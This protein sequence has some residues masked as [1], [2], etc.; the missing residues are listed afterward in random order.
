M[1]F[2]DGLNVDEDYPRFEP[3]KAEDQCKC[4]FCKQPPRIKNF[5][6]EPSYV[7][8]NNEDCPI[9]EVRMDADDWNMS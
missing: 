8:C 5:N 1:K 9:F 4:R 6:T 7:E 2:V 3:L